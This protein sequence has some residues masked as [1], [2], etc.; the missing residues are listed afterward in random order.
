MDDTGRI[1]GYFFDISGVKEICGSCEKTCGV[2]HK[3]R[4]SILK[5]A[6]HKDFCK[7]VDGTY[8]DS[9]MAEL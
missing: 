4:L 5:E 3:E 1:P 7:W 8:P 9:R 6:A 2:W